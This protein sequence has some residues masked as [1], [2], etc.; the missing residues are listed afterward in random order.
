MSDQIPKFL[1]RKDDALLFSGDGTFVFYVPEQFFD[2]KNAIIVGEFVNLLGVLNYT[3][4]DKNGKNSGLHTF[5]FPSVFLTK[6]S[7]IEKVKEVKLTKTNDVQDYRLLKYKDGDMIVV[8]TKVPQDIANVEDFYQLFLVTGN[9]PTTIP[10]DKLHEYFIESIKLNGSSYGVCMQLFGIVLSEIC[11]SPKDEAIPFRL[12]GEKDMTNYKP[13]SIKNIPKL[14]S[15][16][17][18][19]TSENWDEAVVNAI[20]NKNTK[21]SPMEKILMT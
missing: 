7:T 15:P 13:T 4:E 11:R 18:S 19:I 17:S 20:I 5:N 3:I 21:G 9:I 16:Y 12:S 8:S 1:K 10:Y 2:S 6:P 14:I